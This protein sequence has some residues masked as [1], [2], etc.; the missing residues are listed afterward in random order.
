MS[1]FERSVDGLEHILKDWSE[2]EVKVLADHLMRL[3]DS[4]SDWRLA[5]DET[6]G[7]TL[8]NDR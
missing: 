5:K 7:V 6:E 3:V 8:N 1:F 2:E 4:M